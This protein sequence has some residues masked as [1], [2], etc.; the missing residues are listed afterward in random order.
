[1]ALYINVSRGK[2]RNKLKK[3][4]K[5]NQKVKILL[6]EHQRSHTRNFDDSEKCTI[7][8]L[9]TISPNNAKKNIINDGEISIKFT[10]DQRK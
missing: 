8:E 4:E 9:S 3:K 7:E 10:D 2:V 1:M 5:K 6:K